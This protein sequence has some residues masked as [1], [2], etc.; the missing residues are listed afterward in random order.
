MGSG[1]MMYIPSFIKI[2]SDIQ[3]FMG[4]GSFTNIHT[5][6]HTMVISEAYFHF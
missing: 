4:G 1:S 2:G 3:N 5:H 6:I